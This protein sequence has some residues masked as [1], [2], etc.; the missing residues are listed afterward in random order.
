MTED[1]TP[2]LDRDDVSPEQSAIQKLRTA[3]VEHLASNRQLRWERRFPGNSLWLLPE[4]LPHH[5]DGYCP[6]T[7]KPLYV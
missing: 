4:L 2:K 6:T 5:S 7:Q 1:S 3:V